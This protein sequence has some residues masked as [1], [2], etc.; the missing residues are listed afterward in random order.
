M[1]KGCEVVGVDEHMAHRI[2]K[3]LGISGTSDVVDAMVVL[4]AMET[5]AT[6]LTSDPADI[7]KI[8]EA[9]NARIPL[10]TV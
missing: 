8:A 5:G 10:I 3:V 7:G 6:V 4:V 9:V 1:A 2:G